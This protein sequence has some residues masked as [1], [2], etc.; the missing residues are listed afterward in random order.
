MPKPRLHHT[1]SPVPELHQQSSTSCIIPQLNGPHGDPLSTTTETGNRFGSIAL[2]KSYQ[3]ELCQSLHVKYACRAIGSL[4][5]GPSIIWRHLFKSFHEV[6]RN[7]ALQVHRIAEICS[8][9][10]VYKVENHAPSDSCCPLKKH[11]LF[12]SAYCD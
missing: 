5:R 9:K 2:S 1:A 6:S 8:S 10:P 7:M 3:Q 4:R 12:S 11:E